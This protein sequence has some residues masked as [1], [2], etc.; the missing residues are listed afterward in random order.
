[1]KLLATRAPPGTPLGFAAMD[2]SAPGTR[3]VNVPLGSLV[4][5]TPWVPEVKVPSPCLSPL[6]CADMLLLWIHRL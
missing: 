6:Q 5:E 2:D 3:I 1:M 4:Q